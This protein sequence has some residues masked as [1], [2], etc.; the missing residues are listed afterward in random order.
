[1]TLRIWSRILWGLLRVFEKAIAYITELYEVNVVNIVKDVN[2]EINFVNEKYFVD[3][4]NESVLTVVTG[5]VR[6]TARPPGCGVASVQ[7]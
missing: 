1:M 7:T 6:V 3:F 5:P 2:Y 4:V